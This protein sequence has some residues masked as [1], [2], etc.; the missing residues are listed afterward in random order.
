MFLP[1]ARSPSQTSRVDINA[2]SVLRLPSPVNMARTRSGKHK[3]TTT[4][5]NNR[6]HT[7][8]HTHTH[9]RG[10]DDLPRPAASLY[11]AW[12]A[13]SL[14]I[15][16]SVPIYCLA[17]CVPIYCQACCVPIYC[18]YILPGMRMLL[19]SFDRSFLL[20]LFYLTTE[21]YKT[22]GVYFAWCTC[23][24]KH[25]AKSTSLAPL[26]PTQTSRTHV[27]ASAD[28]LPQQGPGRRGTSEDKG[29]HRMSALDPKHISGWFAHALD[30]EEY[31]DAGVRP[32]HDRDQ[33][34]SVT[35]TNSTNQA[36]NGDRPAS[37]TTTKSTKKAKNG[38]KKAS[39]ITRAGKHPSH[40]LP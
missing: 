21:S 23:S 13:A 26:P 27:A 35:S 16:C 7:H 8:T 33:P 12:P 36:K 38:A 24:Y 14:Y 29:T 28:G 11:I 31:L 15:A 9:S 17:C 6:V 5:D 39:G 18:P 4:C 32:G 2:D 19:D 22:T 20:Y 3:H 25:P 10:G 40:T 34:A 37:V 1:R 30:D